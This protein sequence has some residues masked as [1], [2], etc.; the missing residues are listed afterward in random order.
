MTQPKTALVVDV[1]STTDKPVELQS[2]SIEEDEGGPEMAFFPRTPQEGTG[3]SVPDMTVVSPDSCCSSQD[4]T[5]SLCPPPIIPDSLNSSVEDT[6]SKSSMGMPHI[7]FSE[8]NS[9]RHKFSESN[10]VRLLE[11]DEDSSS[12]DSLKDSDI[13]LQFVPAPIPSG[14]SS[15]AKLVGILRKGKSSPSSRTNY[16]SSSLYSHS[17]ARRNL[18]S[19]DDCETKTAPKLRK[20]VRFLDESNT[21]HRRFAVSS[22]IPVWKTPLLREDTSETLPSTVGMKHMLPSKAAALSR[23]NPPV[24]HKTELPSAVA[25]TSS[26]VDSEFSSL[27]VVTVSEF[28]ADGGTC[29]D[30][31]DGKVTEQ[32]KSLNT[33]PT[34]E[35]IDR[36]WNQIHQSLHDTK[37]PC[38]TFSVRQY[39]KG[40]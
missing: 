23:G 33:T 16:P 35:D 2:D 27:N 32:C 20:K 18:F 11:Y 5:P 38:K 13:N 39:G 21:C 24:K 30:D 36:M 29:A 6:E 9:V 25:N 14:S 37:K 7:G 12:S 28:A 17:S 26:N 31:Q 4:S 34:D 10:S 40:Y 3:H 8:S 22:R 15:K 1:H 19:E